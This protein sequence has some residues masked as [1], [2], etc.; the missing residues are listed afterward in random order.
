M[1]CNYL[2]VVMWYGNMMVLGEILSC[3]RELKVINVPSTEQSDGAIQKAYDLNNYRL[4]HEV[5]ES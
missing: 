3:L 4:D 5:E 2:L 1:W